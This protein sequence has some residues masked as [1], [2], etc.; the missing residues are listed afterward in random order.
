[1]FSCLTLLR[2]LV[3]SF[4]DY[5][6]HIG[7][8]GIEICTESV[9]ILQNRSKSFVVDLRFQIFACFFS[10]IKPFYFELKVYNF[11]E[12]IVSLTIRRVSAQM[13]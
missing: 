13:K 11:I 12:A 9:L 3:A 7:Y 6:K 10:G 4:M 2:I 1:M 8:F 5:S